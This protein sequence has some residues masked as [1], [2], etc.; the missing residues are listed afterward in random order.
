MKYCSHCGKEL[1]DEAIICPGCGCP[2]DNRAL[3]KASNNNKLL[4]IAKV[5]MLVSIILNLVAGATLLIIFMA[6]PIEEYTELLLDR[7]LS[8][9][10]CL[11][12]TPMY[13]HLSDSIAQKKPISFTF[14]ILTLLFASLIAGILLLCVNDEQH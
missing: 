2:T 12:I 14:K 11:W 4:K 6:S 13:L 9:L 3:V 7:L 10:P 8:I 5:F 1:F